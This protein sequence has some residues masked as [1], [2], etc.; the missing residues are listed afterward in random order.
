MFKLETIEK[1]LYFDV[2][3]VCSEKDL[4]TLRIKNPR[5][6]DLWKR[7]A[8]YYRGVNPE[9]SHLSDDDVYLAKASLEPEFAKIVCV[10]FGS[11]HHC[12][13]SILYCLSVIKYFIYCLSL[14]VPP[15]SRI[16]LIFFADL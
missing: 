14:M 10:S 13:V 11:F 9:M 5:L 6:A 15:T 3:T 7:R 1:F 4:S 16:L 2:E 8:I 12:S